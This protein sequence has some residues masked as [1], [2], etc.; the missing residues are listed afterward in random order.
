MVW[1]LESEPRAM[2]SAVGCGDALL[3]GFAAGIARGESYLDAARLGAAAA[4]D[5]LGR[6]HPGRVERDEVESAVPSVSV[7]RIV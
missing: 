3:G 5:K 4:A 2:V 1:R 6:A 7:T